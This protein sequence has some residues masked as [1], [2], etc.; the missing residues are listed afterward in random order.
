VARIVDKNQSTSQIAMYK[1]LRL[2]L[3]AWY[4]ALSGITSIL[5]ILAG[6]WLCHKS[7]TDSL[8]RTLEELIASNVSQV[9]ITNGQP[10]FVFASG[11]VSN[12]WA[13]QQSTL[14]LYDAEGNL[15]AEFGA[16]GVKRVMPTDENF[17]ADVNNRH[18]R[19][20]VDPIN[21]NGKTA[22]FIEAQVPTEIRDKSTAEFAFAM[23]IL[24]PFLLVAIATSG[25]LFSVKASKP[26]ETAYALLRQFMADA[27]H[28]LRTPVHAIQLTAENVAAEANG[29][30]QLLTDMGSITKSTDRMAKL[31]DDMMMLTK[32]ELQQVPMKV[33]PVQLDE[34]IADAV[35]EL[36]PAFEEKKISLTIHATQSAVVQGDR[37]SLY[38]VFSNLLQ[39]ALRYTDSGGTVEINMATNNGQTCVSVTDTGIGMSAVD[40]ARIFDRFFRA[41]KSRSR[42]AGGSGLGLAIVK[43]IC[44]YHKG[45]ISVDSVEGKGSTFIVKL[46]VAPVS[47]IS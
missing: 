35:Q 3:T 33:A 11:K 42:A 28:E 26:V 4:V 13:R 10:H 5:L 7:I 29:N 31:I 44:E 6:T 12:A 25:Y 36:K 37:D 23:A 24:I 34:L 20:S 47:V 22:G 30:A 17:E 14:Q 32:M 1:N 2:R 41:D 39:N 27:S 40:L 16:Q 9:E 8:D 18:I 38:R 19:G 15:V 43:S 45:S 21:A 46:P